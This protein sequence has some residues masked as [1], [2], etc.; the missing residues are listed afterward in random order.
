MTGKHMCCLFVGLFKELELGASVWLGGLGL[1]L[2]FGSGRDLKMA[3]SS[4]DSGSALGSL[5]M[6]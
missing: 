4:L 6:S 2:D 5:S 3:R 1:L